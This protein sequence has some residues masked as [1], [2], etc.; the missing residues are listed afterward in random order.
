[1]VN[2]VQPFKHY[3]VLECVSIIGLAQQITY[4]RIKYIYISNLHD[5][6]NGRSY[7]VTFLLT[8]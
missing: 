1:M 3:R 8:N 2:I 4:V 5:H 6:I 7:F